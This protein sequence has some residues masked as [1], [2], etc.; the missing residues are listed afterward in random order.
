MYNERGYMNEYYRIRFTRYTGG[1][2]P[3]QAYPSKL[4]KDLDE[5]V[6]EFVERFEDNQVK[7]Y[8]SHEWR[9]V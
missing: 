1:V 2:T 6:K 8:I 4:G 5:T 7:A 9:S 3:E